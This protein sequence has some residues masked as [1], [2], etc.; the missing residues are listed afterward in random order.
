M[1]SHGGEPAMREIHL[2]QTSLFNTL[3]LRVAVEEILSGY[4]FDESNGSVHVRRAGLTPTSGMDLELLRAAITSTNLANICRSV[5]QSFSRTHMVGRNYLSFLTGYSALTMGLACLYC[6]A[7][8]E[9]A[10]DHGRPP[11]REALGVAPQKMDI[12][13]RQLPKIHEYMH[14]LE[15]VHSVVRRHVDGNAEATRRAVLGIGPRPLR[16]L[17]QVVIYILMQS[18]R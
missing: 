8:G 2:Y 16:E 10:G 13:R 5:A 18:S 9:E 14:L 7:A 12:V 1:P 3:C 15:E 17:A 4:V 6:T 11:L